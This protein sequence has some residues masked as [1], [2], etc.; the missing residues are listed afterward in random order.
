M[1]GM[2]V[3][4]GWTRLLCISHR[5]SHKG[6]LYMT[7]LTY[8]PLNPP[9]PPRCPPPGPPL[10]GAPRAP[11]RP[12]PPPRFGPPIMRKLYQK[13]R[14]RPKATKPTSVESTTTTTTTPCVT[15]STSA[16][17]T[18]A[19]GLPVLLTYTLLVLLHLVE[20]LVRNTNVFYLRKAD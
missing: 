20:N 19:A 8:G 5:R 13:L 14:M 7:I 4:W 18:G 15:H 6:E 9:R 2:D 10:P 17:A 3:V 11:P 12:A 16:T 1:P